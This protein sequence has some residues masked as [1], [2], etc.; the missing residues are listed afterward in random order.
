[1]LARTVKELNM[2]M[3][4]KLLKALA[5]FAAF[6]VA[7]AVFILIV[8]ASKSGDARMVQLPDGTRVR[9]E[10]VTYGKVH[11]HVPGGNWWQRGLTRILPD[12]VSAFFKTGAITLTNQTESLVLWLAMTDLAATKP[13]AGGYNATP[14]ILSD[15]LG[16][17]LEQVGGAYRRQ[18]GNSLW[19]AF[20]FSMAPR[21]SRTL[22]FRVCP[23]D[24]IGKSNF[25]ADFAFRNPARPVTSKWTA[26]ALSHHRPH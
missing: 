25:V 26:P 18:S 1:M 16:N 2:K 3:P 15:N 22:Q 14:G 6:L 24:Y 7:F 13:A 10:A 4:G 20:E 11:R 23:W 8:G 12:P 5:A 21:S 19:E 9:L 17:E